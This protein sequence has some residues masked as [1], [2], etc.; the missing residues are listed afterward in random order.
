MAES[1]ERH[2]WLRAV[3]L[4][5]GL[6]TRATLKG[7]GSILVFKPHARAGPH[8]LFSWFVSYPWVP[9]E[10]CRLVYCRTV[11]S[12]TRATAMQ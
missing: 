8:F 4:G 6:A 12:S 11:D 2:G 3:G 1:T 5:P 10:S 7:K 9:V